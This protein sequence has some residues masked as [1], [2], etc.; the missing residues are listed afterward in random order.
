MSEN[1]YDKYGMNEKEVLTAIKKYLT[2][3]DRDYSASGHKMLDREILPKWKCFECEEFKAEWDKFCPQHPTYFYWH[4]SMSN[5]VNGDKKFL[6]DLDKEARKFLSMVIDFLDRMY[7]RFARY[8][9]SVKN[10]NGDI[11]A[12]SEKSFEDMQSCYEDMREHAFAE[13]KSETVYDESFEDG[14][15]HY[16]KIGVHPRTI[17]LEKF[18]ETYT[19]QVDEAR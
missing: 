10:A 7:D 11:V 16:F 13:V 19:Y 5:L 3:V 17:T 4:E 12:R 18:A 14:L 8:E 6:D 1:K 9:W 2:G 15:P